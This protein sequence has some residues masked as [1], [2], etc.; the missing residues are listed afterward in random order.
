MHQ[1]RTK[2]IVTKLLVWGERRDAYMV[3]VVETPLGKEPLRR[4]LK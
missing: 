4:Q 3:Y 1:K 2:A